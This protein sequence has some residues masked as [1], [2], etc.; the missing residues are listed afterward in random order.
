MSKEPHIKEW[1][2]MKKIEGVILC[3]CSLWIDT[4]DPEILEAARQWLDKTAKDS[5]HPPQKDYGAMVRERLY[6]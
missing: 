1:G 3:G 4:S 6:G 2:S 5:V